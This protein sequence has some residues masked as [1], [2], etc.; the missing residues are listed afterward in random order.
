MADKRKSG[1]VALSSLSALDA[2]LSTQPDLLMEPPENT[3]R[4][5]DYARRVG[6]T[7]DGAVRKLNRDYSAGKLERFAVR[8]HNSSP[9]YYYRLK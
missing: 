2:Y 7:V 9:I 5:Q 1:T 8:S 4:A 3:F 6:M